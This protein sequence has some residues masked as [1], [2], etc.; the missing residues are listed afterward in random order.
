[1]SVANKMP[2]RLAAV[3]LQKMANRVARDGEVTT[4]KRFEVPPVAKSYYLRVLKGQGG[5]IR[6]LREMESWCTVLDHLAHGRRRMALD[7]AASR[8]KAVERAN[9]D[10]NWARAQFLE[11]LEP[12]AASLAGKDEEVLI[13][14]ELRFQNRIYGKSQ[15]WN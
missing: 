6:N 13:S 11:L 10:G 15:E 2:G 12:E 7:F 8:L 9:K 5:S 14:E 4:W 1:M 3:T